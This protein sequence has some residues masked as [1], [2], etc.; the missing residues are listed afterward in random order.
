MG[1]HYIGTHFATE[2]S[3]FIDN[4]SCKICGKS[5][6]LNGKVELHVGIQH[7]KIIEIL[8]PKNLWFGDDA[9]ASRS[10][11]IPEAT[12]DNAEVKTP[13]KNGRAKAKKSIINSNN[14][15]KN[16]PSFKN[17]EKDV[18]GGT[19]PVTAKT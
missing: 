8:R 16:S 6:Q 18:I 10:S 15:I 5:F 14:S 12:I 9:V 3:T 7:K 13:S 17:Q 2:I 11:P 1:S 4:G 19:S